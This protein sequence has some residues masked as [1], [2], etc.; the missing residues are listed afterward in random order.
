MVSLPCSPLM[1]LA[2]LSPVSSSE[3]FDPVKFSNS[4]ISSS[5]SP[6][7][8]LLSKEAITP[9]LLNAPR[10]LT[11]SVPP[12]PLRVLLPLSPSIVSSWLDP[13]TFSK[14]LIVSV[15]TLVS[16]LLFFN[17]TSMPF[18]A[19]SNESVSPTVVF[20]PP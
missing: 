20:P 19:C 2:L 13:V 1:I 3:C 4:N 15:P 14:P 18:W 10:K 5:P 8:F 6:L 9:P 17:D 12:P 16:C 11:V 7:A